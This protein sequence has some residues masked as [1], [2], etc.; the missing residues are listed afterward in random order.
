[1]RGAGGLLKSVE[2]GVGGVSVGVPGV[3]RKTKRETTRLQAGWLDSCRAATVLEGVR[4]QGPP[5]QSFTARPA[6]PVTGRE[7]PGP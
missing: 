3:G 6:T 5:L 4:I 1:M 7:I 2:G